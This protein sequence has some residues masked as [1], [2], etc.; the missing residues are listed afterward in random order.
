MEF[1][2]NGDLYQRITDH[3]NKGTSFDETDIWK[4]FIQ[5]VRGLQALHE[6]QIMHRDLKVRIMCILINARV[7]MYSF[8]RI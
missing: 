1:A 6:L 5:V 3:Q 8:L 4:F 7:R 2:D